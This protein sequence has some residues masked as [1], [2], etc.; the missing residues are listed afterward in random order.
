V[1][2]LPW[3][4][5]GQSDGY[6]DP[7]DLGWTVGGHG[8]DEVVDTGGRVG[9]DLSVAEGDADP[10]GLTRMRRVVTQRECESARPVPV[11]G[12]T[13]FPAQP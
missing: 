11:A 13:A 12:S 9:G 7:D 5:V 4:D 1:V 10:G 8:G 3:T 2:G 6:V